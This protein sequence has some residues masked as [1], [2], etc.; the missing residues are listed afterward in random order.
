MKSLSLLKFHLFGELYMVLDALTGGALQEFHLCGDLVLL[1]DL[2]EH[3]YLFLLEFQVLFE[4]V[5]WGQLMA[6]CLFGDLHVAMLLHLFITWCL[7]RCLFLLFLL[8]STTLR[9][10]SLFL[11]FW[12][13]GGCCFLFVLFCLL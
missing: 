12:I 13:L 7:I 9:I 5:L 2:T 11:D 10:L 3:M 4:L 8:I 1:D 6:D